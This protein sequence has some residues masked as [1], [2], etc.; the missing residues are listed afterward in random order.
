MNLIPFQF[1]TGKLGKFALYLSEYT[2]DS[3]SG[4]S[5]CKYGIHRK[6]SH[7]FHG[8]ARFYTVRIGKCFP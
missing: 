3:G 2:T 6:Q 5:V 7:P 8:S 4:L 1:H